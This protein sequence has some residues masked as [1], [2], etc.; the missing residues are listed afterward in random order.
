MSAAES[1]VQTAL[2]FDFDAMAPWLQ[3]T[4][5]S[6]SFV[7]RGEFG[8]IGGTLPCHIR[9]ALSHWSQMGM[10]LGTTAGFMRL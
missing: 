10:R 1:R 4:T 7:S 6:P 5:S 3:V 8:P 2:T 9:R